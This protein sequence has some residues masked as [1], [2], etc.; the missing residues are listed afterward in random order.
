MVCLRASTGEDWNGMMYAMATDAPGCVD[1][2]PFHPNTCGMGCPTCAGSDHH[3]QL[4]QCGEEALSQQLLLLQAG[5]S[6]FNSGLNFSLPVEASR[7]ARLEAAGALGCC[8][9]ID[10]CGSGAAVPFWVR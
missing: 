6:S 2:P 8:V 1:D 10:G 5:N 7:E 4:Q 9:A 3:Q